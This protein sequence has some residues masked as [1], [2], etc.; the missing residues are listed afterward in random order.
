MSHWLYDVL[1]FYYCC[2]WAPDCARYMQRRPSN[3]CRNYRPPQL[4]GCHPV[5]WTLGKI[6]LG[7]A[8]VHP[9]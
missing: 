8:G 4:G 6:G 1:S 2:L 9:T 5:P 3:D 7:W